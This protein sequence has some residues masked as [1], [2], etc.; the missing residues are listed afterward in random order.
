MM[1]DKAVRYLE[2]RLVVFRPDAARQSSGSVITSE[3]M[4]DA[5]LPLARLYSQMGMQ[6]SVHGLFD[7]IRFRGQ[8]TDAVGFEL[9]QQWD[10]AKRAYADVIATTKKPSDDDREGYVRTLC[11]CGEW[12]AALKAAK[13]SCPDDTGFSSSRGT[14]VASYGATA[15]WI[16]GEWDDLSAFTSKI[17]QDASSLQYLFVNAVLFRRDVQGSDQAKC[18][19]SA[20]HSLEGQLR[21]LLPLGPS[22]AYESITLLQHFHEISE[23]VVYRQTA[24]EIRRAQFRDEWKQRFYS[25]SPDIAGV[26]PMLRSLLV[27]A[28]VVTPTE[29]PETW[30][31]FCSSIRHAYPQL[32]NWAMRTLQTNTMRHPSGS[33]AAPFNP[34]SL[35]SAAST[36]QASPFVR[37]GYFEHLW[38]TGFR[39]EAVQ[40][41][42]AFACNTEDL[43]RTDPVVFGAAHLKLGLWK[44]EIYAD[45]F[46]MGTRRAEVVGHLHFAI[47]T[48]PNDYETWHSWA[49]INYRIQQR[50]PNQSSDTRRELVAMAHQ[51]FVAAICRSRST[52]DALPDMMRLLQLWIVHQGV[53]LLK[54]AIGDCIHRIPVEH[55]VQVV[56]QLIAH[57]GHAE[58]D[59]REIITLILR[60]VCAVH[61]QTVVFALQVAILSDPRDQPTVRGTQ[62]GALLRGC[63]TKVRNDAQLVARLLF[64]VA[65]LPVENIRE[66]LGCV[67][68]HLNA[69]SHVNYTAI[70]EDEIQ[71]N[72][73]NAL[74]IANENRNSLLAKVG[75]VGLHVRRVTEW[76]QQGKRSEAHVLLNKLWDEIDKHVRKHTDEP[77][78]AMSKLLSAHNL[79]VCVFG[80]DS[81]SGAFPTIAHFHPKLEV[82]PSQKRPRKIRLTGSN[83]R[84]Y[85]FCLKANEDL[86][87]D[88]RVM[89]LFGLVNC[90][91]GKL[92]ERKSTGM[93]VTRFPVI[94][95]HANVGLLGWVENAETLHNIISHHRGCPADLE[96]ENQALL[97]YHGQAWDFLTSIQRADALA[98]VRNETCEAVDVARSMWMR[99]ASAE[100]WL[101]RRTA[102]TETLAT[103]SM[104]GYILGLGDRHLSNIMITMSTGRI[105]H[106]DFGDSFD[107]CR[108]RQVYPETV[109]FRLTNM[110]VHA[111]EVFGVDGIF[112]ST[113][114]TVLASLRDNR[115]SITALL[116]AFVYDPIVSHKSNM[117]RVMEKTR[118]PQDIV[119]RIRNKLRGLEL[120]I[121]HDDFSVL[122]AACPYRPDIDF[123]SRAFHDSARRRVEQQLSPQ[124]QV[125]M[126]ITEAMSPETLA[127]LYTGWSPLW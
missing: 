112:R 34:S 109:P 62:A 8:K 13:E 40:G 105:V 94:P 58:F 14:S 61:P 18:I 103:M 21:T 89:Q 56:P 66:H 121:A 71:Q 79:S 86:R 70:D 88:E 117:R 127:A 51:G 43:D 48:C 38:E 4:R 27:H 63:A 85:T 37:L 72:L 67:L 15:A 9:L 24:S 33:G 53:S 78:Q 69:T 125:E 77:Q 90:F 74:R 50:D 110:L 31:H 59:V 39:D 17:P 45:S 75:D 81:T 80:E 98:N 16:L 73:K 41:L 60:K 120:A 87:L 115:D 114:T 65:A 7:S 108:L 30:I 25:I 26:L 83:G 47:R 28:L 44:Q 1:F 54:E 118:S 84:V 10:D 119:E 93:N 52:S 19:F 23:A 32:A 113:C 22:H 42:E 2:N 68:Q 106:I 29:M 36:F 123:V 20:K 95:I 49:L 6:D 64:D 92:K 116:S 55:W 5:V 76:Y 97:A 99:S 12:E 124:S 102:F 3:F 46:W 126:L 107:S 101:E 100:L 111:M 104:V 96:L 82:I 11:F 57:L 35:A 91:L 122:P